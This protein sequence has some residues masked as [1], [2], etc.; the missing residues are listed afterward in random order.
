MHTCLYK[1]IVTSKI[2]CVSAR[3]QTKRTVNGT[4]HYSS[5]WQAREPIHW[6]GQQRSADGVLTQLAISQTLCAYVPQPCYLCLTEKSLQALRRSS[7]LFGCL[8]P[9]A[10]ICTSVSPSVRWSYESSM[11]VGRG[12]QRSK[13]PG[14]K[15]C[16]QGR[17][18]WHE[19]FEG[20]G[21]VMRQSHFP[22]CLCLCLLP[23]VGAPGG[24]EGGAWRAPQTLRGQGCIQSHLPTSPMAPSGPLGGPVPS[25]LFPVC[26]LLKAPTRP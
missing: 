15:L 4:R 24:A 7:G 9:Q 8:G 19:L 11:K 2:T 18:P 3:H 17:P 6:R 22:V 26:L 21:A 12:T 25:T 16:P 1:H 20:L 10:V 23:Q 5:M 14:P 13:S